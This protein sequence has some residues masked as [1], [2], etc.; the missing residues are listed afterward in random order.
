L[1][2]SLPAQAT[3]LAMGTHN[4]SGSVH[5]LCSTIPQNEPSSHSPHSRTLP[6][7]SATEPHSAFKSAQVL[8]LHP[9]GPPPPRMPPIPPSPSTP[10]PGMSHSSVSSPSC[11]PASPLASSDLG[12]SSLLST[13]GFP[14]QPTRTA[15]IA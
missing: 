5:T 3:S 9:P 4:E 10:G 7:P 11:L 13:V 1:P 14:P 2:H 12:S 15:P 8:G 6:Q